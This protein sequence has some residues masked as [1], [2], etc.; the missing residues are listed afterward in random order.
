MMGNS[1]NSHSRAESRKS[2]Q[3]G[4]TIRTFNLSLFNFHFFS[5]NKNALN[6]TFKLNSTKVLF[7]VVFIML[8]S[9]LNQ[10]KKHQIKI[11]CK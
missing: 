1:G 9:Y 4:P 3:F 10:D 11:S 7:A 8:L 2:T 5:D 6:K